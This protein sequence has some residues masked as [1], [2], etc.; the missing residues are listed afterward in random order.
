MTDIQ[1][2]HRIEQSEALRSEFAKLWQDK[3]LPAATQLEV[4]T[5]NLWA[6][7]HLCWATF[8]EGRIKKPHHQP[9][10]PRTSRRL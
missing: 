9:N 8:R 3:L 1:T 5:D 10:G 7:Q 6:I 4:Q 2:I